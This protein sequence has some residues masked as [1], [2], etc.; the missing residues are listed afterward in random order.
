ML[1]A[2]LQHVSTLPFESVFKNVVSD[3]AGL[4]TFAGSIAVSF[5]P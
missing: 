2:E 5:A 4:Q 1:P 3:G